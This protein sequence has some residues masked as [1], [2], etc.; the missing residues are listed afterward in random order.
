METLRDHVEMINLNPLVIDRFPVKAPSFA[1]PEE[2][3]AIWYQ[4][5]DKINGM[6]INYHGCFND[7]PEGLQTHVFAPLGVEIRSRWLLGGN[8]PGEPAQAVEMG[9]GI[10]RQG[11]YLREDVDLKCNIVMTSF[12]KKNLKR[13]HKVLVDR[14]L[15]KAKIR[16]VDI[17]NASF[18][19]GGSGVGDS[20]GFPSPALSA[21]RPDLDHRLSVAQS[22][23]QQQGSLYPNAYPSPGSAYSQPA[24][25][26]YQNASTPYQNASAPYP[27]PLMPHKGPSHGPVIAELAAPPPP[28]KDGEHSAVNEL[29]A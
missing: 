19:S 25:S 18:H 1:S 17:S 27:A 3:H 24:L 21:S 7:L 12:V 4:I 20:A 22:V 10:P 2:Y 9:L 28:P 13:S 23:N 29:P 11:L 26:P 8:L 16:T 5:I 6:K 14:F 15:E